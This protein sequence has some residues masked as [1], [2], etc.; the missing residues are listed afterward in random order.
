MNKNRTDIIIVLDRSGSMAS[1]VNDVIGG[2]NKLID[3]Q[4]NQPGE[5]YVTLVQFNNIEDIIYNQV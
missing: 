4:I 1:T 5:A 3:D 2:F